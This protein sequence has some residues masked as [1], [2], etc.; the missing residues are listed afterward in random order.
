MSS[1][2]GP[3]TQRRNLGFELPVA[4]RH[5]QSRH[6]L[7]Q[8]S[9]E[10]A[11]HLERLAEEAAGEDVV[12][13]FAKHFD[14]LRPG[15]GR[16]A[17]VEERAPEGQARRRVGLVH[18]EAGAGYANRLG[19]VPAFPMLFRQL[20]KEAGARIAVEPATQFVDAVLSHGHKGA[21]PTV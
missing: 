21:G 15:G 13:R 8:C 4:G 1:G 14:Q 19:V 3:Q 6:V 7:L 20:G 10:V 12:G 18:R 16:V 9:R 11:L 2:L 17:R 5:P